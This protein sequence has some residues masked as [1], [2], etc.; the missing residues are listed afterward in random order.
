MVG[1][2]KRDYQGHIYTPDDSADVITKISRP[3]LDQV[4]LD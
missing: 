2:P 4:V 3:Y 1:K